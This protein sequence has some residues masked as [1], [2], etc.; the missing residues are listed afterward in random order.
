[1]ADI[2][3]LID[4]RQYTVDRNGQEAATRVFRVLQVENEVGAKDE[5]RRLVDS[6]SFPGAGRGCILNSVSVEGKNGNTVFIVTANYSSFGGFLR[7]Q[8]SNTF[9]PF[10]GWGYR[11]VVVKLPLLTRGTITTSSGDSEVTKN[12]W[13]AKTVDI[14]ESRLIRTYKVQVK[15]MNTRVLDVIAEQ[16]RK[17][18]NINGQRCLFTGADVQQDSKDPNSFLITYTWELDSGTKAKP[19]RKMRLFINGSEALSNQV[20]VPPNIGN[21]TGILCGFIVGS[22]QSEIISDS[23][24]ESVLIRSPFTA[25][26]I[27]GTDDEYKLP[28]P[29]GYILYDEDDDGWKRL[30]GIDLIPPVPKA[31]GNVPYPGAW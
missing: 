24:K 7:Q 23:G 8:E 2:Q 26:D 6:D 27:A 13:F 22:T 3:E 16:D 1:M 12:V 29:T 4:S 25:V 21:D 11:K 19:S 18:H 20:V 15:T 17:I 14:S 31:L 10:F 5:F 9:T 28:T 30:P